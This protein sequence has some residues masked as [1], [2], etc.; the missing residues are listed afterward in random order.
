MWALIVFILI[1]GA[2]WLQW[3]AIS[4]WNGAWRLLAAVP[5]AL[6]AADI[7]WIIAD[8]SIDPTARNLW[9]LELLLIGACGG[10]FIGA[11]WLLRM[12]VR[13]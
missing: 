4:A 7:L 6:I 9:P 5:A 13:A 10:A 12:V 3:R 8:V 2:I 1:G 11:L